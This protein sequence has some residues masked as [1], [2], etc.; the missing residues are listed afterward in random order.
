MTTTAI[1]LSG[2]VDSLVAA[3]LLKRQGRAVVGIHFF[4]GFETQ[5]APLGSPAAADAPSDGPLAAAR[6]ARVLS[7]QLEIPVEVLDCRQAFKSEV[8]AYFTR[9]YA[10]GKTPNPCLTCNPKIKFGLAFE[11]ART[12]GAQKLATGHY[13]RT[14]RDRLG[15]A[16][17]LQGNDREK[18]QSYFL[19]RLTQ[20]QLLGAVFPLGAMAKK[21][22]V[23]MARENGLAPLN[24]GESQDICFSHKGRYG[25]FLERQP[26]FQ[27]K[28]GPIKD[29][30]GNIIGR[31]PGLHR[32]TIG[33][34]RGINCPA[35]EPYYVIGIDA[36]SNCLT[37]GFKK[38]TMTDTCRVEKINWIRT[39]PDRQRRVWARLRYR[40]AGAPAHLSPDAD[41]RATLRFLEPQSAV[42]PGQGAVFYDGDEVLGGGWIV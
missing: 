5:Q 26:G 37:V 30:R 23:H 8:V 13:A 38:D 25:E 14:M 7:D 28:S 16:K 22:T 12:L 39:K 33:Q 36:R 19:A 20:E 10:Q 9:T 40:H 27:A 41:D 42:T 17:L 11:F 18:D 34:R 24:P 29:V 6:R 32:F 35:G 2:G 4:T 3:H 21:A 1:L 31:H 15:L